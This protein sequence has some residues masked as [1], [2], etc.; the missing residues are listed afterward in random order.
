MKEHNNLCCPHGSH[1]SSQ[2]HCSLVPLFRVDRTAVGEPVGLVP[3]WQQQPWQRGGAQNLEGKVRPFTAPSWAQLYC[4]FAFIPGTGPDICTKLSV[5]VIIIIITPDLIALLSIYLRGRKFILS[6]KVKGRVLGI[7]LLHDSMLSAPLL[8]CFWLNLYS[9]DI[10]C[11]FWC[12]SFRWDDEGV[13]RYVKLPDIF[14]CQGQ[15][16]H[17][18]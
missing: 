7:C 2:Q 14:D 17:I 9:V 8:S 11:S 10:I 16:F 13:Y 5:G 6:L 15:H 3:R 1:S 18:S 4:G 12:P